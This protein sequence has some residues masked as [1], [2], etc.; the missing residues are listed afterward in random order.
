MDMTEKYLSHKD[1]FKGRV[2][3]VQLHQVLLPNGSKDTRE[4]VL[5]QGGACVLPIDDEQNIYLV[6][7]FRYPFGKE[8]FEVPAGKINDGEQPLEC[9]KRE[10]SEETGFTAESIEPLAVA[11]ATP[12]YCSEILSIYVATGLK[13]GQQKLDEGEFLEVV[14]IP[15]TKAYDMVLNGEIPDA[16]TQIAILRAK[17]IIDDM[18]EQNGNVNN[19]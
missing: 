13:K 5:H 8:I 14:K 11:Y 12:A 3:D 6:K 18:N 7:Q 19:Q 10:L 17:K 16:K 9:A 15:Y 2:F 1:I 4:V